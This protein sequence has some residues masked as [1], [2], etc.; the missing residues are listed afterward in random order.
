MFQQ[1]LQRVRTKGIQNK[2]FISQ[3]L[4][5]MYPVYVIGNENSES[6]FYV[7]PM[8]MHQLVTFGELSNYADTTGI[9]SRRVVASRVAISYSC[10]SSF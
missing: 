4:S 9:G 1:H 6:F 3:I 8:R 10:P 7:Q 5:Y 2:K